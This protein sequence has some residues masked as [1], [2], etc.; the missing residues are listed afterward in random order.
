MTRRGGDG[1]GHEPEI[2]VAGFS[3]VARL[4]WLALLH[5][6]T[7]KAVRIATLVN[8]ANVQT[9]EATLRDMP[10]AARAIGLQTQVL[11]ASTGREIED[12]FATL[13]SDRSEALFIAPDA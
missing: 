9:T 6:L 5:E 4:C 12:A 13:V 7:P 8:P 3:V 10:E 1:H 11:K 2:G